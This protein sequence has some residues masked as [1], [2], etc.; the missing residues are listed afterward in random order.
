M[1]GVPREARERRD[2]CHPLLC[3]TRLSPAARASHHH[4]P[5]SLN[6]LVGF[7]WCNSKSV[8]AQAN[9]EPARRVAGRMLA[10]MA[11]D[12]LAQYAAL[13]GYAPSPRKGQL[14]DPMVP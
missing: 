6:H 14:D 12:P 8:S 5:L 1:N 7:A 11:G 10:Q 3:H 13:N 2:A 4:L 9:G